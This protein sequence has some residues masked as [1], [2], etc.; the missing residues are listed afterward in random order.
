MQ[1]LR[2]ELSV[3]FGHYVYLLEGQIMDKRSI[4]QRHRSKNGLNSDV[5][6]KNGF[7]I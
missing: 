7:Y 6:I 1:N 2:P 4:Q 3:L 5:L